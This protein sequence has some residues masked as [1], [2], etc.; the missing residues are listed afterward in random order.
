[1][2]TIVGAGPA[3]SY[4]AYLLAKAGKRVQVIEEHPEIGKPVQ[5][6]GIVTGEIRTVLKGI[7]IDDAAINKIGNVRIVAPDGNHIEL[8]LRTPDLV[9]DRAKFDRLL[10]EKA[11]NEGAEYRLDTRFAGIEND[12]LTLCRKNS[13]KKTK[14]DILIGADGPLS[15]V[16]RKTGLVKKREFFF[17]IQ[18][19]AKLKNDNAVE[20]YPIKKG[21]GWTVPE[22]KDTVRIGVA[23]TNNSKQ[24]FDEFINKK[25][26]NIKGIM[27]IQAGLIPV[28]NPKQKTMSRRTFLVGDAAGQVKATTAGGIV[29]GLIGAE[30]LAK[31]ITEGKNYEQLW[32]KSMGKD[33]YVSLLMRKAMNRFSD[34]D[35]NELVKIF[36]KPKNREILETES[37]DKMLKMGIKLAVT[38]PGLWKYARHI[39]QSL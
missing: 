8:K 1:M 10:A 19:R 2:I 16:G 15:S 36:S 30:C 24:A 11:K 3:G 27:E 20:F 22:N 34:N 12:K 35:Y 25:I 31:A 14:T 39:L 29:Q 13:I 23:T 26:K 9:L 21:F 32:K 33:L 5:C 38:E 28:Y 17:G 4:C 6:T 18:A 37:R 7:N